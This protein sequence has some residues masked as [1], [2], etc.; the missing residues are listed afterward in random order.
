QVP[1]V[2]IFLKV[3]RAELIRRLQERGEKDIDLRLSRT[4]FEMG[5]IGYYDY[6]VPNVDLDKTTT[7]IEKIIV[8]TQRQYQEKER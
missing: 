3:P 6:V 1:V 8:K 2:T 4:E 5:Y 7:K